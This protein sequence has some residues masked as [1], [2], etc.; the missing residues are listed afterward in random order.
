M[1]PVRKD[2]R[3]GFGP[4]ARTGLRALPSVQALTPVGHAFMSFHFFAFWPKM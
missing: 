1:V 4:V 3:A 2:Q